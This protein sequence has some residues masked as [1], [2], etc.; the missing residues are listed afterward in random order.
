MITCFLSGQHF[1][2]QPNH[3]KNLSELIVRRQV[4]LPVN[5][6]MHYFHAIHCVIVQERVSIQSYCNC[7][8]FNLT[9]LIVNVLG[10]SRY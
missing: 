8:C 7:V 6:S 4:D 3:A 9:Y 10:D 5:V 1:Q 2:R